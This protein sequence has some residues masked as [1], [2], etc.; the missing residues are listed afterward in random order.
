MITITIDSGRVKITQK[1][2]TKEYGHP[3]EVL[4]ASIRWLKSG[5]ELEDKKV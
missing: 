4:K 2:T 5:T 1:F 3:L